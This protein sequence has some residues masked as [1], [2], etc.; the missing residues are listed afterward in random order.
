M[1][2]GDKHGSARRISAEGGRIRRYGADHTTLE[3]KWRR[4]LWISYRFCVATQRGT[5]AKAP[6]N[7]NAKAKALDLGL[8]L[9]LN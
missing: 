8:L 9:G 3:S 4:Q 1:G 2:A 5:Q 6:A 7:A